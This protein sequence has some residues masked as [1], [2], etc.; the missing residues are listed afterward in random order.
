[1]GKRAALRADPAPRWGRVALTGHCDLSVDEAVF[2]GAEP[3][4]LAASAGLAGLAAADATFHRG[5]AR[6]DA[7]LWW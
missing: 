6:Q 7:A 1:M 4:G 2:A 3:A 5:P